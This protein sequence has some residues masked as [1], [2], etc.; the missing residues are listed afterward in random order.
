MTPWRIAG[1]ALTALTLAAG[2]VSVWSWLARQ[3][4]TRRTA[5][6]RPPTA[7]TVDLAGGDVTIVPG[8]PDRV[9]V[10]KRLTWSYGRPKVDESWQGSA[11]TIEAN[12]DK[13]PRLPGCAVDLSIEAPPTAMIQV[14]TGDGAI[15]IQDLKGDLD[16]D[17]RS[18]AVRVSNSQGK[19]RVVSGDGDIT[20]TGLRSSD[21]AAEAGNGAVDLT[22]LAPPNAVRALLTNGD[23]TVA[24][25]LADAYNVNAS[26]RSGSRAITVREGTGWPRV[27]DVETDDGNVRVG[28]G[29]P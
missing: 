18:G 21:V 25:P 15:T 12:C 9:T 14:R 29:A 24:V 1:A 19:L 17:T 20:G 4:E 13:K 28:Y 11:L 2:S 22:F 3:N 6:D 7:L 5:Y 10:E 23:V 26:T 27:I 8:P 16:L